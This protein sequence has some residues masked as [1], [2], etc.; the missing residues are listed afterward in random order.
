MSNAI[1]SSVSAANRSDAEATQTST[2]PTLQLDH[3]GGAALRQHS[4][5]VIRLRESR[6]LALDIDDCAQLQ[7]LDL[8]EVAAGVTLTVSGC[9]RLYRILLPDA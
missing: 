3:S 4:A 6:L 8:R 1:S 2:E 9:P 5:T 7:T